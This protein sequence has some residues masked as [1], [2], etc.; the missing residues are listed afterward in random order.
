MPR[1]EGTVTYLIDV[2]PGPLFRMGTVHFEGMPEALDARLI[3]AW[4]LKPGDPFTPG[5]FTEFLRNNVAAGP[6][7]SVTSRQTIVEGNLVNLTIS[8]E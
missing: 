7:H 2:D 5:Y 4:K 8:L 6:G 1:D 3:K